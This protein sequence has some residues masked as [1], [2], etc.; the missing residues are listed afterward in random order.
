[1]P[2]HEAAVLLLSLSNPAT[3]NTRP[4]SADSL[5]HH[6]Q[7]LLQMP[8]GQE[9]WQDHNISTATAESIQ[10][11]RIIFSNTKT[12]FDLLSHGK[13]YSN[14][15]ITTRPKE[16]PSIIR[17]APIV[18][19][20]VNEDEDDEDEPMDLT[21][22]PQP[23]S[24]GNH[25]QSSQQ[26]PVIMHVSDVITKISDPAM[27]LNQLVSNTDKIPTNQIGQT[28][29]S[30]NFTD[31]VQYNECYLP[32]EYITERALKDARIKQIQQ[33]GKMIDYATV[34]AIKER[35]AVEESHA[36]IPKVVQ[37]KGPSNGM[38]DALAELASKSDKLE[39]KGGGGGG[40][41]EGKPSTVNNSAKNV[42]SE[43]LKLTQQKLQRSVEEGGEN[44]SDQET[45]EPQKKLLTPQTI[46]VGEDGFHKK[47]PTTNALFSNDALLYS[48]LQD[49]SG[50]PVCVVCSKVFQKASQLKIHMNIHY[51]ERK[52]RCEACGVSF[53]T[54]GHLQKHERSVSHQNK[55]NMS[56]TFGVPSVSNP[57]PFKCKDCK[58]AFRI[59]GHLAK[60]LRSKMHVLKLE[61]LQKLP[62][63]TYAEMERAGFNL[64]DIDTSDC[65]NSLMSL[66]SLAKKLNEKDPS[67]LGPL[68]PLSNDDS[69]DGDESGMNDNYDSDSSDTGIISSHMNE[70]D[71]GMKRKIDDSDSEVM[72]RIKLTTTATIESDCLQV[73]S[74]NSSAMDDDKPHLTCAKN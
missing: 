63:G 2:E 65:D 68:P 1:M 11:S 56:S 9:S 47:P 45:A 12:D 38:M 34:I 32:Q 57:R 72:K 69:I 10:R 6:E 52:F 49:D 28:N 25:L 46:V 58:I 62:F 35:E 26:R 8:Q 15:A 64:T 42:A 50:R 31:A 33:A 60:H 3:S 30:M 4:S 5:H 74:N 54:Q 37:Q 51:M 43:Y 23:R 18:V 70:D 21:K 41:E 17:E 59:H 53:R 27:L 29:P 48:H 73:P 7:Q 24:E 13:Y 67:K 40:G 14:P 71:V 16:M 19:S 22:K 36:F 20:E 66:R 44:S 61:C 39:I 55:V